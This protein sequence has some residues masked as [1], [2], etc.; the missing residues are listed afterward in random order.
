MAHADI[1]QAL[2]AAH[3]RFTEGNPASLRQFEAQARYM[4]GANSR[5]V[6]FYAPFPLTIAKG[7]GAT[8]WDADGHRYA[9]FIAEYTAGVYGHSAPEIREA[10]AEAMNSGINLTGHNLLEGRLARLICER[11]AQIEQLRFTN[12]GT[13]ANLMALTAA[14]HFTGRRKIV[15]FTGGY[16]G[17]VLGFGAKPLPTTVPFDF[18]V[19]PYNDERTA[20]EQIDRH[21]PEI[22]AVLLEPM[23]GAS[24]CIPARLEF[25]Q[26][27][28]EL[29]TR[30]GALLIFD[31]VMTSRLAPHGLANKLGIRSDLTTLGKYIGGGMS[32][33]AFGGR[34]DVMALFDPRTG[35]LAHSGTFNNNVL[36][37]AAG[38]A[39]LT[40]L[41]T[42]EAAGAL[43]A[44]G[45]AMRQR[46][47]ALCASEGVAMQFTGIGSLMNAHFVGGEVRSTD[48]LAPVDARLR[49]LLFFHLLSEGIYTSP[50]GFVVLS[51]PL[52]DADIDRYVAAIGSFIGEYRA[53]LPGAARN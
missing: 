45:D 44:R 2:A 29:A 30:V 33:G 16:H 11:F 17:G 35:P 28:R 6:L 24:G 25:L 4:P 48:D 13:E 34:A 27:L 32:F 26:A 20:R 22:A 15:V 41:F 38:H 18:L 37:M 1:D 19:L 43:A 49:Q 36:T 52:T 53:L 40:K 42:P 9:D 3:R 47:N 10:V 14:L 31:E 8:L 12:S 39:G 7:E 23:Q 5:S 21:G 51:L 46:L 50:R